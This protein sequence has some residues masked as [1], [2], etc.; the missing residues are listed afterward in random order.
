MD[1]RNVVYAFKNVHGLV[2]IINYNGPNAYANT[3]LHTF[4][5]WGGNGNRKISSD[6]NHIEVW[7]ELPE[8]M[9]EMLHTDS[10]A[11]AFERMNARLVFEC[12]E[13]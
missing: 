1:D 7:F 13:V 2:T 11:K 4:D 9:W 10:F 5:A 8:E 12:P 3:F 6:N